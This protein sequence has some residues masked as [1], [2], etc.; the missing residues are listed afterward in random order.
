MNS[1]MAQMAPE[2]R[3]DEAVKHALATRSA[4]V[5]GNYCAF[6][7]LY[8]DAPNMGAYL[9]DYYVKR[10]RLTALSCICRAYRPLLQTVYLSEQ[11]AFENVQSCVDFLT[12]AGASLLENNTVLDCKASLGAFS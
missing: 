7:R 3:K 8:R 11:L 9:M 4:L 10:E 5:V 6:F 12:E 2:Q 1:L